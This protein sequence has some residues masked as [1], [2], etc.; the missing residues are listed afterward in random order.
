M[1][2]RMCEVCGVRPATLA[3]RLITLGEP[4]RI[5]HLC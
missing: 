1:A 2:T 5:E 4:P 3:I